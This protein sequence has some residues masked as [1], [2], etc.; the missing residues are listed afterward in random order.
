[1]PGE[2]A[3]LVFGPSFGEEVIAAGLGGLNFSWGSD[4][5]IQGRDKLSSEQNATLDEVIANHDPATPGPV[6][7]GGA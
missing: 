4:G 1:M 7:G 3:E 2:P 6:R 5:D